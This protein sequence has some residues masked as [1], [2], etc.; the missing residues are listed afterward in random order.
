ML[1]NSNTYRGYSEVLVCVCMYVCIYIYICMHACMYICFTEWGPGSLTV[2]LQFTGRMRTIGMQLRN[3]VV[4]SGWIFKKAYFPQLKRVG[5][6]FITYNMKGMPAWFP[7]GT[8]NF[9]LPPQCSRGL[10]FIF[11][12]F[13]WRWLVSGPV[14][15]LETSVTNHQP[16][17]PNIPEEIMPHLSQ[18]TCSV[19]SVCV[20][21]LIY[22]LDIRKTSALLNTCRPC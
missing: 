7:S 4:R 19:P 6:I 15:C 18:T 21:I 8:P 20:S 1:H 13:T 2:D 14:G 12:D 5:F 11:S 9:R 17:P 3:T 10:H 22:L 16:T